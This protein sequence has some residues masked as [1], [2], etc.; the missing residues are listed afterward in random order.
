VVTMVPARFQGPLV[1]PVQ[2]WT[3]VSQCLAI[4]SGKERGLGVVGHGGNRPEAGQGAGITKTAHKRRDRN[5][6]RE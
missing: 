2:S 5:E 3:G 1:V 6:R 4:H